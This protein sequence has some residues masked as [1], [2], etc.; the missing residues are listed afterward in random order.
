MNERTT[1]S[2]ENVAA[3]V[4]DDSGFTLIEILIAIVL[5]GV[6]SAVAVVGVTSLTS[7]GSESACE[8]SLD[9]AKAATVVYFAAQDNRYP[10]NFKALSAGTDPALALPAEVQPTVIVR[11]GKPRFVWSSVSSGTWKLTMTPGKGGAKPTFSCS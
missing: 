7:R 9:A 2:N 10:K 6:L 3:V 11:R 5:I 8:A 4:T 1:P